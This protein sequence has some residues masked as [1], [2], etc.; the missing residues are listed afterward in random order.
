MDLVLQLPDDLVK[1]LGSADDIERHVLEA[2]A[3]EGYREGLLTGAQVARLLNLGRWE[4]EEFLGR[5]DARP[6][7]TLEM[8]EEDRRTLARITAR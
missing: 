3:A 7:Y 2:L 1:Q 4:T 8:L 5:H 6:H